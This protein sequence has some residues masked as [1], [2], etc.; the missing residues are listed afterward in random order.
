MDKLEGYSEEFKTSW[1]KA[2]LDNYA[3]T[4]T[5]EGGFIL[6]VLE[7]DLFGAFA[8]ADNTNLRLLKDIVSYTYNHLPTSC[9]GD[10]DKIDR[11]VVNHA[12]DD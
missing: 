2:A 6:A 5:I 8:K 11:W 1:A 10:R 4:G 12:G 7:G 3:K 9:Y